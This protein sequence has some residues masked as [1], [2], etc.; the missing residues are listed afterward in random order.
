MVT[1]WKQAYL[2]TPNMMQGS[3]QSPNIWSPPPEGK[4]KCNVDAALLEDNVGFGAVIRNHDGIF[5]AAYAGHLQ[6]VRDPYI[7]ETVAV[8]EALTWIKN[9]SMASV[10][11][12][13]DSMPRLIAR[14][15]ED[16]VVRHVRRSTNHVAHVLAQATDHPA[17]LGVWDYIP[18]SCISELVPY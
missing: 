4:L 5:V 14:D 3:L 15:I 18:P 11:F 10:I 9:R 1:S 12:E 6:C 2:C 8:K 16:V 7:A 17:V 13:S